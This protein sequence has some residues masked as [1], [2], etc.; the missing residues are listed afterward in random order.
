MKLQEHDYGFE[1]VLPTNR[2]P[3]KIKTSAKLFDILSSGIYKD[4]ILAVIRELSCNAY[5][6]HV[7]AKKKHVPFKLRLPTRLDPTFYV[8]DEGT[9]IDPERITDIY[10]TYGESSKTDS[11]DQIGALGLGSKSPFAY[12]K[13]SFVVKN[14]YEGIEYTYLCFINEDG[15][16]DGSKVSDE[17]TDKPSGVT[18]EFAV[19]PEDITAFFDRTSR[20]FKRWSAALP[21]FVDQ[22]TES[23]MGPKIEKVIEGTDWYLEK[24]NRHAYTDHQGAVALQGNVPYP[25]EVGS[26]PKM[27]KDL[28]IIASNPFIITFDMGEI[29]FASSRE[30][31]QYDERTSTNVIA[32]LQEVRQE[33]EQS[34]K[35][36]IFKKGMT[37]LEFITNF[38]NTFREFI[39]TI[40]YDA[41]Y[42]VDTEAWYVNLLIGKQKTD[43]IVYDSVAWSIEQL[44]NGTVKLNVP[45]HQAFGIYKVERK[46]SRSARVFMKQFT[47]LTYT[48]IA[49]IDGT[50]IHPMWNTGS[51]INAETD[52][53]FDWKN[54]A[55]PKRAEMSEYFR[56]LENAKMFTVKTRHTL[57]ID[58]KDITFYVNDVGS[59]GEARY[60]VLNK[61]NSFF[62]NFDPKVTPVEDVI[63]QLK[64]LVANGLK[65]AEI[66]LLSDQADNR[67]VI[68]KVKP[69]TGT[70]RLKYR[71]VIFDSKAN[72]VNIH[73]DSNVTVKIK[74]V[75]TTNNSE[76]IFKISDLQAEPIVMYVVKRR[77]PTSLYDDNGSSSIVSNQTLMSLAAAYIFP[78]LIQ[79]I[80]DLPKAYIGR[81]SVRLLILNDGQIE[82]LKKRKVNLVGLRTLVTDRIVAMEASEGFCAKIEE[83]TALRNVATINGMHDVTYKKIRDRLMDVSSP[84]LFKEIFVKHAAIKT[85]N[86]TLSEQ[87]AKMKILEEVNG[88]QY[89]GHQT[90]TDMT[91]S[92]IKKYPLLR[93]LRLDRYL[94]EADANEVI[95]YIEQIDAI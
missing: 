91:E 68:D 32:R 24:T 40:R 47:S 42:G 38:R 81:D 65:G 51:L 75:D 78:E 72:V 69:E 62:V 57:P 94:N 59:S 29:N 21:I 26:I 49:D 50:L 36:K 90:S 84:S 30:A 73:H 64:D 16:P 56:V 60:K 74:S 7:S 93:M 79:P 23:I 46:S 1:A 63:S 52:L 80:I 5:D 19:R 71:N 76:S 31:L 44:I 2:T 37:H 92:I 15:M 43:T 82:W 61:R 58:G 86:T 18:V 17:P 39:A 54:A 4:K 35:A 48:A 85:N 53:K 11:N 3:F 20:F 77:S 89:L 28:V 95:N 34:F 87:Y 45:F 33:I 27:P 55:I 13:S 14:R 10:W 22:K 67:P 66:E 41:G 8:E 88:H 25:I 70:I 6:A 12:T 9:G 83:A